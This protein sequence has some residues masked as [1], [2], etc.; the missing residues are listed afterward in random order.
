MEI[1]GLYVAD[2]EK[3]QGLI[4]HIQNGLDM[5]YYF[6]SDTLALVQKDGAYR[7]LTTFSESELIFVDHAGSINLVHDV[8]SDVKESLLDKTELESRQERTVDDPDVER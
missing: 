5:R 8:V 4:M 7:D 1:K 6:E 3:E 2:L